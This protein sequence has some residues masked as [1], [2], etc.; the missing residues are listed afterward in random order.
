MRTQNLFVIVLGLSFAFM[1]NSCKQKDKEDITKTNPLLKEWNTP[2]GVPPFDE[3]KDEHYEPAFDYAMKEQKENIEKII[4]N[5]EEP[6]FENTIEAL[7]YSGLLLSKVSGVFYNMLSSNT[8]DSLQAIAQRISPK[9]SK[10]YD[11]ITLNEKLFERIEKLYNKKSSLNL[12]KEQERVLELTYKSFVRNGAKLDDKRKKRLM[13]INERLSLLS[14]QFGDNML[15][16]TNNFE[17]TIENEKDLAGLPAATIEAAAIT[18]KE[19]G[20]E[21]KWVFTL[22]NPSVMPFLQYASNREL[23]KKIQQAYVNRCNNNNEFDNKNIIIEIL[24]LRIERAKLLGYENHAQYVL[25]DNM[26]KNTENVYNLLNQLWPPALKVATKEADMYRAMMKKEGI[27][28]ELKAWD[29]RYYTEK[30]RKEKYNLD[31]EELK[32]YFKLENVRDGI[33]EVSNK[34]FGLNFKK[35]NNIPVY[36]PDVESF[37][38]LNENNEVI[39]VLYMDYHP[40][41]SKR[42]GA[43]MNTYR[44]QYKYNGKN[45]I[46]IITV[47]C[48]FTK[49]TQ[50]LPSLLTLDEVETLF[51]EFGHALHGI[52]SDCTYPSVSGTSVPRDFVELPSQLMEHWATHPQV[53]KKY[54]KHYQTNQPIP[55]ELIK[56]IEDASHFNQGFATTEFLASALL[57][58]YYHT[59]VTVDFKNPVEAENNIMKKLGLIPEIAPRHRSTYFSHIFGGGYSAG[60]YSYIWSEV[61]DSDAF[62]AFVEKGDIFDKETA[63]KLKKYIYSNGHKDDPMTMYINFRGREPKIDALLKNRGLN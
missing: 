21:G 12:N 45:V 16:E 47:N 54:A 27:N 55:D 3:I 56:K 63:D 40:R 13:E 14:L 8:N 51:H 1:I 22:H 17:L 6:T 53:I 2:Y 30:V 7:E 11:E 10:H 34:L 57:D 41:E 39:A 31:E 33:F 24:N 32:P 15:A 35:V 37:E 18:A 25:E 42:G 62:E 9:L 28:E 52:L 43:W 59:I 29:W 48:N 58:M 38:V 44:D 36:H 49:P 23:R 46:P 5:S 4:N 20:Y 60:Y 19:K 26:A 50:T 61:L